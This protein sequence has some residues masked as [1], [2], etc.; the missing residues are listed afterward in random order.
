M[1]WCIE[2]ANVRSRADVGHKWLD[3]TGTRMEGL[4]F[5]RFFLLLQEPY[6]IFDHLALQS[7]T[8]DAEV[9]FALKSYSIS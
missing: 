2:E 6:L 7:L 5:L 1:C 9:I 3:R 4:P 8:S